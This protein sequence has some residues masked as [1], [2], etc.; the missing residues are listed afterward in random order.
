MG[1]QT[2]FTETLAGIDLDLGGAPRPPDGFEAVVST[3]HRDRDRRNLARRVP[4]RTRRH[5]EGDRRYGR[6]REDHDDGDDRVRLARGGQRPAWIVGGVVPQLG[7]NAGTGDGWLVV[8]GDE[9]DR[10]VFALRPEIA[11][12]TNVELTTTRPTGPSWTSARRS[13]HVPSPSPRSVRGWE[14]GE[15]VVPA[16]RAR[17]AQP[18]ERRAA[19]AALLRVGVGREQA[20]AALGRFEGA[21][22]RFELVGLRAAAS[23]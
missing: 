11:V 9:S 18:V 19:L 16:R 4:R 10:S 6:A 23:P 22:R 7:G 13:T 8:E 2:I 3:A 21:E 17:R 5:A 20:E 1:L 12:V 15:G 14:P